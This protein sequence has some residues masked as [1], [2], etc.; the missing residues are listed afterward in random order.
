MLII[1]MFP[2]SIK[3]ITIPLHSLSEKNAGGT[4]KEFF[5]LIT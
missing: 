4:K 1:G 2:C 3:K 5:E